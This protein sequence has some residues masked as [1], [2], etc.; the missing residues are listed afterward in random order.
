MKNTLIAVGSTL[1]A[2]CAVTNT[3]PEHPAPDG[4]DYLAPIHVMVDSPMDAA[5]VRNSLRET[6]VFRSVE[7]GSGVP[8]GY[9]VRARFNSTR[10]ISTPLIFL[11]A[12]TLFLIPIPQTYDTQIDYTLLRDDAVLKHYHYRNVTRK[13]TWLLDPGGE[14]QGQ[15]LDR[16]SQAFAADV[17][18]D[19]VLPSVGFAQ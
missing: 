6:G 12:A 14:M 2:G 17:Q 16:I 8:G 5:N 3:L 13:Y 19:H 11:S 4:Q 9:S 18:H 1:L 15:N 10:D 7:A